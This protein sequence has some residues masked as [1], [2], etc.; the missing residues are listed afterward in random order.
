MSYI[1]YKNFFIFFLL[2]FFKEKE[3]NIIE[4][5]GGGGVISYSLRRKN[6]ILYNRYNNRLIN[7]I[8]HY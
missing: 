5:F 7:K 8:I 6:H 4:D 1:N 2:F 3:N